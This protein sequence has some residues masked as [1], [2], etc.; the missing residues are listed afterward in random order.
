MK[1][2]PIQK[3]AQC[4][5]PDEAPLRVRLLRRRL[6]RWPLLREPAFFSVLE[7][8][9]DLLGFWPFT[10]GFEPFLDSAWA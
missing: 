7:D 10:A 5:D 4:V 2:V 6:P 1:P 3:G 8:R 9:E